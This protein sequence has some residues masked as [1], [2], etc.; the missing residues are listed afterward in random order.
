MLA[1]QLQIIRIAPKTAKAFAVARLGLLSTIVAGIIGEA[2]M[3]DTDLHAQANHPSFL[4][5][6]Y[7]AISTGKPEASSKVREFHYA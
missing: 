3:H 2:P 1:R 4:Q 7:H 5:C 6:A